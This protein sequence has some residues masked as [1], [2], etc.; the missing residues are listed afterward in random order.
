MSWSYSTT[1]DAGADFNLD[2]IK[3]AVTAQNPDGLDQINVAMTAVH[4][5]MQDA[6]LGDA[7][8]FYVSMSGHANPGHKPRE[9]W[10]NDAI[11]V[12]VAYH[13]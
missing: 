4:L 8:E 3:E 2:A 13:K 6:S 10:A 7:T 12:S 11:T 5:L 1:M 9:G